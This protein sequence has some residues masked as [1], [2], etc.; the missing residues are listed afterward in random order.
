MV[1]QT[2]SRSQDAPGPPRAP[3]G[4]QWQRHIHLVLVVLGLLLVAAVTLALVRLTADG[5]GDSE[6]SRQAPVT[7]GATATPTSA[8]AN[9]AVL[10]AYRR[11]GQAFEEAS[12]KADPNTPSLA[13][14]RT[15]EA[16]QQ[17]RAGIAGLRAN[18]LVVRGTADLQDLRVVAVDGAIATV[19]AR[20]CDRSFKYDAKTGELRDSPAVVRFEEEATLVREA[21]GT[22]KV[23][24]VTGQRTGTCAA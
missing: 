15:G 17:A 10:E 18:G 22:W 12:S 24:R 20:G 1:P 2:S 11:S 3:G 6:S 21:G 13:L 7:T 5:S 16:L 14:Y 23:S 9:Q 8:N 4:P 19:R